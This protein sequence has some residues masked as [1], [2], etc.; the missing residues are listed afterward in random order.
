MTAPLH[1]FTDEHRAKPLQSQR[2]PLRRDIDESQP[3]A[4]PGEP[5]VLRAATILRAVQRDFSPDRGVTVVLEVDESVHLAADEATLVQ[6]VSALLHT[7]V[8]LS[9]YGARV[10]LRCRV[11]ELGVAIEVEDERVGPV[12][13]N[14]REMRELHA[15]AERIEALGRGLRTARWAV[16]PMG[17]ELFVESH[18]ERGRTF[19]LLF[20]SA[21]ASRSS[22]PPP[23]SRAS[24]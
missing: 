6:A 17:G 20:P 16:E 5:R 23:P 7:A 9:V 1:R 12:P 13:R 21:S 15:E 10:F 14:P 8:R 19:S 4:A 11:A 3:V 2:D 22:A 18:P 24:P